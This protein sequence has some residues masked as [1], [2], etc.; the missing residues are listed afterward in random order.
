M[1]IKL[2]GVRDGHNPAWR[3]ESELLEYCGK[4][5]DKGTDC[6]ILSSFLVTIHSESA[7]Y[8]KKSEVFFLPL[9]WRVLADSSLSE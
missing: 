6:D 5:G 7:K 8:A 9:S 4:R 1:K 3:K 2:P